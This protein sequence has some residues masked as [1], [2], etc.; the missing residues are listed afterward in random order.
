MNTKDFIDLGGGCYYQDEIKI[1]HERIDQKRIGMR[2]LSFLF[3]KIVGVLALAHFLHLSC[4]LYRALLSG[5]DAKLKV[6][7]LSTLF[8]LD[9]HFVLVTCFRQFW[10]NPLPNLYDVAFPN[11]STTEFNRMN[12][13]Y[14]LFYCRSYLQMKVEQ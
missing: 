3:A 10:G 7:C 2:L 14:S 6:C 13:Q 1:L 8:C 9:I 4:V 5:S 11:S 12:K